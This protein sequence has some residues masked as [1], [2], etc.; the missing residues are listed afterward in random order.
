MA[1]TSLLKLF[2]FGKVTLSY[3]ILGIILLVGL[4][5]I[6]R[7]YIS[8]DPKTL[9]KFL[10][11]LL[12]GLIILGGIFLAWTGR[13]TWAFA[14]LPALLVWFARF[15]MAASIF[16]YFSRMTGRGGKTKTTNYAF[17]EQMDVSEALEILGLEE[18]ASPEEIKKA[19]HKL[20]TGLHP[21]HGGSNYLAAK[22]NRA[23]DV[24]LS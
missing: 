16:K 8:A 22:I 3:L 21:D 5:L 2:N 14:S 18:G 19:H 12:L 17:K 11:W 1:P 6:L 7:S 10:K 15:R 9:L 23:K 4:L 13:L 20:I 24:L